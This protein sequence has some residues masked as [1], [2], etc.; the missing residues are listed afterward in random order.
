MEKLGWTGHMQAECGRDASL[1]LRRP[2][3]PAPQLNGTLGTVL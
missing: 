1:S 3:L 2:K